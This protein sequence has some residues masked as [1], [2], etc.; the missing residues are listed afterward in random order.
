MSDSARATHTIDE[1][2]AHRQ[3]QRSS[4]LSIEAYCKR[5]G[6]SPSSWWYWRN[7][8]LKDARHQQKPVQPV[9]FLQL[10][11][12]ATVDTR[13]ELTLP[14]GSRISMPQTCE[15]AVVH[16]AIELLSRLRP[17]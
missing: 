7:R 11:T 1:M 14:N 2:R 12:P 17:R 10:A 13:L 9:S 4:G 5:E 15:S 3:K 8:L 6:I 16:Q